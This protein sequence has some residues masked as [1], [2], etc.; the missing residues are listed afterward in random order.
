MSRVPSVD[1][2]SQLRD[3]T[4]EDIHNIIVD[5]QSGA[6]SMNAIASI[7]RHGRRIRSD[8]RSD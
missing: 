7:V 4:G 8:V 1:G 3:R 5:R 2:C 6:F